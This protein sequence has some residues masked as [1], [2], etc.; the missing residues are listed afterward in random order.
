MYYEQHHVIPR[1]I[2][3]SEDA[4]NLV[5]LTA[6]EHFLAHKLL[7]E[8]YP[9][10]DKLIYAYWC[11]CTYRSNKRM[12]RIRI[13]NREFDRARKLY[14]NKIRICRTGHTHS[15][16]T[17]QKMSDAKIGSVHSTTAKQCMSQS[18]LGKKRKPFSTETKRKMSDSKRG[19]KISPMSENHKQKIRLAHLNKNKQN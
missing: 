12:D 1:C 6:R 5:L 2:G 13:S 10:N 11:M 4:E 14:A 18:K 15:T 17:K 3:G 7:C 19:R 9:D 16:E 8:I